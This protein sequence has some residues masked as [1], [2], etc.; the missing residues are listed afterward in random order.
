MG[1]TLVVV[2]SGRDMGG[3]SERARHGPVQWVGGTWVV[4]VGGGGTWLVVVSGQGMV[5]RSG[6]VDAVRS[7]YVH[8]VQ[9]V[10]MYVCVTVCH[11]L[12][13]TCLTLLPHEC[14]NVRMCYDLHIS[15]LSLLS[16]SPSPSSL[17]I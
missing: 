4:V 14:S 15:S 3:H 2:V 5:G 1:G 16:L 12:G 8:N 11:V 6:C 7:V 10:R 17:L 13:S 9:H